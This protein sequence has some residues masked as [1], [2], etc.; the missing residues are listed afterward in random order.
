MKGH[1]IRICTKYYTFITSC[2]YA[3][4]EN[5]GEKI[6]ICTKYYNQTYPW[7]LP[8]E[9][10]DPKFLKPIQVQNNIGLT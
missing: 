4:L 6:R 10:L 3:R 9:M 1:K 7:V 5:E 2:L 8:L